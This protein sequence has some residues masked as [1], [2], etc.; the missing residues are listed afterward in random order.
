MGRFARVKCRAALLVREDV[1]N[2]AVRG[3]Y[4]SNSAAFV[5]LSQSVSAEP[6]ERMGE[7][8]GVGE[9]QSSSRSA[10]EVFPVLI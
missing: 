2:R 7:G 1:A 5:P 4:E 10:G 9:Q 6:A 3:T 8:F